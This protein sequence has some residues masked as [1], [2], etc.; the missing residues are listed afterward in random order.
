MII[1]FLLRGM[2]DMMEMYSRARSNRSC[3]GRKD[4]MALCDFHFLPVKVIAFC[5][6]LNISQKVFKVLNN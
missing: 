1:I 2:M 5:F 3:P 4:C 6:K